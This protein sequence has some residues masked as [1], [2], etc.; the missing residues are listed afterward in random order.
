MIWP[1][2]VTTVLRYLIAFVIGSHGVAYLMYASQSGKVL[3][4]WAGQALLLGSVFSGRRLETLAVTLWAVA[5]IGLLCTAVAFG[6]WSSGSDYW[7][8][9]AVGASLVSIAS[10][11]VVWD[12]RAVGF[13]PEG[14][15]GMII[16]A[17]ILL[18]SVGLS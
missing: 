14:G 8:S 15:I 9:I 11:A 17:I 6:L 5:G 18:G 2:D 1:P 7:R 12:G 4:G 10:F 16:S 3:E 13:A